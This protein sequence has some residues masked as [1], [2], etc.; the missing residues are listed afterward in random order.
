MDVVRLLTHGGLSVS[1]VSRMFDYVW[2]MYE[3]K[4]DVSRICGYV[5]LYSAMLCCDVAQRYIKTKSLVY[6]LVYSRAYSRTYSHS[7]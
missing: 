6:S 4:H 2:A 3:V 5:W 1:H 7:Y